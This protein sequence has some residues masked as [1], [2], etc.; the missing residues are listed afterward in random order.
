MKELRELYTEIHLGKGEMDIRKDG[1]IS[2]KRGRFEQ[3]SP[4]RKLMN[5]H[6]EKGGVDAQF[7]Q[8]TDTNSQNTIS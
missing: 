3:Q 7:N 1:W 8:Q 6:G 5:R 4:A 2:G